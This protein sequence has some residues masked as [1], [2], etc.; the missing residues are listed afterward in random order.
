MEIFE[1]NPFGL[2]VWNT[3][4]K[5]PFL[6]HSEPGISPTAFGDA[7]QVIKHNILQIY[8][9]ET[10]YDGAPI[11]QGEIDGLL[12]GS[13]Y[14]GLKEYQER[15][16]SFYKLVFGPKSFIVI[17]DPAAV[18]HILRDTFRFYDKG[19]LAEILKPIMGKGL[20]PADPET[21]RIRKKAIAPG[22]HRAWYN[23]M[24]K[25][26]TNCMEPL[27]NKLARASET[28]EVINME[29]EF[30]SVSLDIIG[31]AV[32]NYEFGSVTNES[33]VVRAVYSA[34]KEA[35]H[36]SMIPFPYWDLPFANQLVPRLRKFNADL[37]ILN[38]VLNKLIEEALLSANKGDAEELENRDYETMANPSLLR[39][40]VDMRGEDVTSHQLRDDLMTMLVAGHETT[41]AVLNWALFEIV[42]QPEL[43]KKLRKEIDEVFG[44]YDANQ[45]TMKTDY[46]MRIDD[47][48]KLPLTRMCLTESLRMYPEP[49]LLIRRALVDHEI[50]INPKKMKVNPYGVEK[51]KIMR[52]ADLFISLYNIHRSEE[53]WKD[54][55]TFNPERFYENV[56]PKEIDQTE[57]EETTWHGYQVNPSIFTSA[58][59][60]NE[61]HADYAFLPFGAGARKCVG[62]QFAF[63]EATIILSNLIRN[64]DFE[65]AIDPKEVGTF[66]GATIHTRNGLPFRI[67]RRKA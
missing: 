13:L 22:F 12:E 3:V 4:W 32:F 1:G 5:L 65:F 58:L 20:I 24:C 17:S 36:R 8:G 50:P 64:F 28:G 26:F 60:P 59:Y 47:M 23:A 37:K 25:T 63:M 55:N 43:L 42:Q 49:P 31:K 33:P 52:G 35:E 15:F 45:T 41:A 40:L 16:G 39:F 7:A 38:D 30:C 29:I 46:I 44:P 6:Q 27:Y 18:R 34:L 2:K 54:P 10:S 56:I 51:L 57:K 61:V 9:N 11:A 53:Y 66:T 21:W 48:M 19:V 67:H 14:L 62:D